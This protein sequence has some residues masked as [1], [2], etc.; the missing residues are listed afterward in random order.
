MNKK[1]ALWRFEGIARRK[2]GKR[3]LTAGLQRSQQQQTKQGIQGGNKRAAGNCKAWCYSE[4]E[5]STRKRLFSAV[6]RAIRGAFLL[7]GFQKPAPEFYQECSVF[8]GVL[9]GFLKRSVVPVFLSKNRCFQGPFGYWFFYQKHGACKRVLAIGRCGARG[10]CM[11][12]CF[13]C[14]GQ[15]SFL[16]LH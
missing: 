3:E 9:G 13:F 11:D 5:Q 2:R 14:E 16:K 12:C 10:A 4:R 6:L 8:R 7:W 15:L 1:I